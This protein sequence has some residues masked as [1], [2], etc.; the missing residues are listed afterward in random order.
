MCAS[1]RTCVCVCVHA[2][3][4]VCACA[5][6]FTYSS[7]EMYLST[8]RHRSGKAYHSQSLEELR[9]WSG[10]RGNVMTVLVTV[11]GGASQEQK[12]VPVGGRCGSVCGSLTC[13]ATRANQPTSWGTRWIM[14]F[15]SEKGVWRCIP[16]NVFE[17]NGF[18]LSFT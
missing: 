6:T 12:S 7:C 10:D 8:W 9:T 11:R 18:I 16:F 17:W 13:G 3:V 15:R 1:M 4:C 2:C 14:V 5:R